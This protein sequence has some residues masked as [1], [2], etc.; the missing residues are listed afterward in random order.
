METKKKCL[1]AALIS[2][3]IAA[4]FVIASVICFYF[5][6]L[7]GLL[8]ALFAFCTFI[9]A[10]SL[11]N[12]ANKL[13]CKKCGEKYSYENIK[14]EV[15]DQHIKENSIDANVDFEVYCPNCGEQREYTRS[16]TIAYKDKNGKWHQNNL[17]N[18]IRKQY[19]CKK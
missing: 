7:I 13:Y 11:L 8:C 9:L 2:F 19:K 10:F 18:T 17:H 4:V 16:Y 14:W 3:I 5:I 15:S 1:R 12:D 6:P